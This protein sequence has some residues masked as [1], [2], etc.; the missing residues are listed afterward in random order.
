[1]E[2]EFY[3]NLKLFL[4]DLVVLFPDEDENIQTITTG[5]NLAIVDD[6]N[7]EIIRKFYNAMSPLQSFIATRDNAIF[8][9]CKQ[10]WESGS[11]EQRLFIRINEN[12]ALFTPSEQDTLWKYIEYLYKLSKIIIEK[13]K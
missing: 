5:I 13:L 7:L 2:T 6:E 10:F 4:K 12:W 11:Y 1:M 8:N 9:N 3:K